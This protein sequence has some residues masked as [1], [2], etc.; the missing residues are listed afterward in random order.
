MPEVIAFVSTAVV[1]IGASVGLSA[2]TSMAIANAALRLAATAALAAATAPGVPDPARGGFNVKQPRPPRR[3]GV[4]TC[5]VSGAY[6]LQEPLKNRLHSVLAYPEGPVGHFGKTWL[7]DDE[8]TV[9]A[10]IVQELANGRYKTG[11]IEIQERLGADTETV[12][13]DLV[14]ALGSV[15]PTDARG[16]GIPSAYVQCQAGADTTFRRNYPAGPPEVSREAF[17]VAYD[18][19]L[20]STSGGSGSHRRDDPTTWEE[21]NNPVVW[22]VN[23]LWRRYGQD[24][25]RRFAP[26]LDILSDEADICDEA[27]TL[28]AGGTIPRYEVGF[29]FEATVQL[30]AFL[31]TM[32]QAMDGHFSIRRD[33]AFIIRAGHY[34]APTVIFG[35]RELIDVSY[36]PGPTPD[37]L[38]NVLAC[39]FTDP[40]T[41][42]TQVE[43]VPW[44]DDDSVTKH[45]ERPQDFFPI[46][47]QSQSQVRRLAKAALDRVLVADGSFKT[48]LS[49]RRG[50]GERYVGI[51]TPEEP[52]LNDAVVE[53][54]DAKIDLEDAS[55][56]WTYK[57]ANSARYSWNAAA[58]EGDPPDSSNRPGPVADEAPEITT[59]T[60]FFESLGTGGEG[61]RL[62]VVGTGPDREDLTWFI[63]WRVNGAASWNTLDVTDED[64][65]ADFEG[66]TG[67]V[68]ANDDL[69][70]Q[71]GY[72]TGGGN[73]TW[74]DTEPADTTTA[75]V[76]PGVVTDVAAADGTGSSDITWRN[77]TSVNLSYLKLYRAT[78]ASFGAASQI[79]S[80]I[81]AD[82]LGAEQTINDAVAAGTY[83]YWVEAFNA[84]GDGSGEVGP[85]SAVVS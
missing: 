85:D 65:T 68:T 14:T 29:W 67:F 44:Q 82:G 28:K 69:D 10:G 18:W 72:L 9:T 33:G 56:T 58:E 27:V 60:P 11:L 31:A 70:V 38:I 48:P 43:V 57:L 2:S 32:L 63:R 76:A 50:L 61:V 15:W 55:I 75:H 3:Y 80:N 5:R 17:F 20:D 23:I 30:K 47:V 64:A 71:I 4:G 54:L 12:Y 49:A 37:A 36:N 22:T 24:W 13:S 42:Y 25:D 45:G 7:N 52:D 8:V 79:G 34:Y 78:S 62:N 83:Y 84:A 26:A 35:E 51:R 1:T 59:I 21:T 19:R 40:A 46:G 39:S 74:S 66:D 73:L 41:A 53:I 6:M 81:P 77:P 16:D